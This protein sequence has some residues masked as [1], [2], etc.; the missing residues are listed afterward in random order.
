MRFYAF[1]S[2]SSSGK[3]PSAWWFVKL[4]G[5]HINF[6]S[7]IQLG[8]IGI[9][10]GS[11]HHSYANAAAAMAFE[12]PESR[13]GTEETEDERGLPGRCYLA[14]IQSDPTSNTFKLN[15]DD[16]VHLCPD[17]LSCRALCTANLSFDVRK[18]S[19]RMSSSSDRSLMAHR[20]PEIRF[21][22]SNPH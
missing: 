7:L 18:L 12:L 14:N 6:L 10:A 9:F 11:V 5:S 13:D 8:W 21:F 2:C 4:R 20:T 22:A 17:R 16:L 15:D 19:F 1:H 3:I